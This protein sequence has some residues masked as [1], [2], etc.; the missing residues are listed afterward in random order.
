M[1]EEMIEAIKQSYKDVLEKDK[2]NQKFKRKN[3]KTK[4]QEEPE[5]ENTTR[6]SC[7]HIKPDY[8]CPVCFPEYRPNSKLSRGSNGKFY[9]EQGLSKYQED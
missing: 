7:G 6:R 2:K 3:S 9:K 4:Q 5:E 1:N 8:S